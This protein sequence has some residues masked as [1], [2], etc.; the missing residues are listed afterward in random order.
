L[1]KVPSKDSN[2]HVLINAGSGTAM[3]RGEQFFQTLIEGTDLNV[4]EYDF[5]PSDKI[6][7]RM[8]ALIKSDT[9]ILVGGGDGTIAHT[10]AL[11]MEH[12]KPFGIIPMGTMNLLARDLGIPLI[13]DE[14]NIFNLYNRTTVMPIDVA[15]ANDKPFLCCAA[16]GTIP[17]AALFRENIRDLPDVLMMPRLT[18]YVLNQMDRSKMRSLRVLADNKEMGLETAI[19][20]IS[21]NR[22][23]HSREADF[24][25]AKKSLQDGM[26]GIYSAAPQTFFERIRLLLKMQQGKM[27]TEPT[28]QESQAHNVLVRTDKSSELVS[29]DGEPVMMKTPISFKILPGALKVI[30]PMQQ[31]AAA[32][33]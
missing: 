32:A 23:A 30:I 5:I 18:A 21:N 24:T 4:K 12:D 15:T 31:E 10:A 19:L 20:A 25:L 33:A 2:F 17:Q 7:D 14:E 1:E 29:I 3:K 22:F 9:P 13:K 6:A 16:I 28:I 26:L 27:E 8:K 11:H